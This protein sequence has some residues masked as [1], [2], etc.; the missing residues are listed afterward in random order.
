MLR[1]RRGIVANHR[2]LF[3]AV[4]GA[5]A[6]DAFLFADVGDASQDGIDAEACGEAG[7]AVLAALRPVE[8]R[9]WAPSVDGDV[10]SWRVSGYC[11]RHPDGSQTRCLARNRSAHFYRSFPRLQSKEQAVA[12]AMRNKHH[13]A[14]AWRLMEEHVARR[15]RGVPYALVVRMRPD[16]WLDNQLTAAAGAPYTDL[17]PLADPSLLLGLG[18]SGF[19]LMPREWSWGGLNDRFALGS[20]EAM[21]RYA[22]Q[23]EAMMVGWP[24]SPATSRADTLF[25]DSCPGWIHPEMF[26]RCNLVRH[27][28]SFVQIPLGLFTVRVPPPR[29]LTGSYRPLALTRSYRPL[30]S[31]PPTIPCRCARTAGSRCSGT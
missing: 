19:V 6:W 10:P 5:R 23:F 7:A 18:R 16:V 22:G 28:V 1:F 15:R 26:V 30:H 25:A 31:P 29:A 8:S 27:G 17:T 12:Q 9:A 24:G 13:I 21:R 2:R 4:F 14:R 11:S 3:D 20:Y